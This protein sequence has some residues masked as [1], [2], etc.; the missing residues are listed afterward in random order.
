[1]T[2]AGL[3]ERMDELVGPPVELVPGERAWRVDH[4]ELV[5]VGRRVDLAEQAERGSPA[6]HPRHGTG[7]AERGPWP[8]DLSLEEAADHARIERRGDALEVGGA[9]ARSHRASAPNEP[10]SGS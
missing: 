10:R 6:D 5:G 3:L 9:E 7:G 8:K 4:R 1:G 2:V